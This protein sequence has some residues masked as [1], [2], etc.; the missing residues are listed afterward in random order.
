MTWIKAPAGEPREKTRMTTFAEAFQRFADQFLPPN[1]SDAMHLRFQAAA[2]SSQLGR[3][4]SLEFGD[5]GQHIVFVVRGATKLVAHASESRDQIVAF[6]FAGEVFTVP[7]PGNH[8]YSVSALKDCDILSFRWTDFSTLASSEPAVLRR[9]LETTMQSLRRCRENAIGLG[10]KTAGERI[11]VFLLGMAERIGSEQD[12]RIFLDL[13]MSRRDIAESLG[14]TIETVSRQLTKLKEE[15]VIQTAGRSGVILGA[16]G[17][18]R[19]RA[20]FLLEA[21]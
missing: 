18:L 1:L 12:G 8:S 20:G 14:L 13:P 4:N 21:A 5:G 19:D 11:A 3:E 6:H 15:G 7:E 16:R 10:R 2:R 17:H 9:L